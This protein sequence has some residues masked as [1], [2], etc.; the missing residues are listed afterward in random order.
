MKNGVEVDD[1]ELPAGSFA[2]ITKGNVMFKLNEIVKITPQDPR[3]GEL[4]FF[5]WNRPI[6][7]GKIKRLSHSLKEVGN[8]TGCNPII[9]D[10]KGNV[11]DHQHLGL[12]AKGLGLDLYIYQIPDDEVGRVA[13]ALNT[14]Q[15][16]WTLANFAKY[17]ATQTEQPEIAQ[18]YQRFLDYQQSNDITCGVLI[19]IFNQVSSRAIFLKNGG[20]QE[21]KQ[22]RL[23]FGLH[24]R[25]HIEDTLSKLRQLKSASLYCPISN[26][27]FRKQQFQE[28]FLQAMEIPCFDFAVFLRNL[29]RSRHSFNKLAKRTDI[30]YEIVRIFTK[31]EKKC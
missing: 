18:I 27:T 19:A 16:N 6:D 29:C 7:H 3:Y 12:A 20:N 11:V 25:R 13:I 23:T 21:F 31:K 4:K 17:W 15:T 24:N 8:Y 10:S 26:R 5:P 28:A 14:N 22:G 2:G 9:V 1:S 30:Y